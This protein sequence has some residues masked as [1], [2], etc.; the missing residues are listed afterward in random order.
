MRR[1]TTAIV[2]LAASSLS[3][4]G[5]SFTPGGLGGGLDW[6]AVTEEYSYLVVMGSPEAYDPEDPAWGV[7]FAR[8]P[9]DSTTGEFPTSC[10][11][12]PA[13]IVLPDRC[14]AD[15]LCIRQCPVNAISLDDDGRAVIDPD[16]CISCGLCAQVCPTDAIFAPSATTTWVL[17]GVDAEG[18]LTVLREMSE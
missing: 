4:A 8:I 18:G 5:L 11:I 10:V 1:L 15:Q 9:P 2:L 3:L 7:E 6:D 14:I 17:F 16:L 12:P 13:F